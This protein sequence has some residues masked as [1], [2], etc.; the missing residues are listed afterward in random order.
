MSQGP[1]LTYFL[2]ASLRV[3]LLFKR[4]LLRFAF[5]PHSDL[6]LST[7]ISVRYLSDFCAVAA[8]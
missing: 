6:E 7:V 8:H 2:K 5:V 1:Y 4:I 3:E